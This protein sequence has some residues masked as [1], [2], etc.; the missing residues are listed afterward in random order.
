MFVH[1]LFLSLNPV[2]LSLSHTLILS[3]CSIIFVFIRAFDISIIMVRYIFSV[4]CHTHT[5]THTL[6][7][8]IFCL[9]DS[10]S[11]SSNF[12]VGTLNIF[13]SSSSFFISRWYA[14][15][16]IVVLNCVRVTTV[17]FVTTVERRAKKT[18]F[19]L[20]EKKEKRRNGVCSFRYTSMWLSISH[21]IFSCS[22]HVYFHSISLSLDFFHAF[23]LCPAIYTKIYS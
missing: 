12:V 14:N 16:S 17:I 15:R 4:L 6:P 8:T 3:R 18:F 1:E 19:M 7:L 5:P 9:F 22:Y 21:H 11:Y 2:Y 10:V 23:F 20:Y 13:S